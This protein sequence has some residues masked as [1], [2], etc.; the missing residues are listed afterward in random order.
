MLMLT[1]GLPTVHN[2]E[3]YT[4]TTTIISNGSKWNGQDPDSI[5]TLFKVLDM[6]ALDRTFEKYGNFVIIE[7]VSEAGEHL[8]PNGVRFFGNFAEISH[9]FSIDTD[10]PELIERLTAAIRKNQQRADY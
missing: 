7:P 1:D 4:M 9:V 5:E 2:R 8:V 10:D 3:D 6:F